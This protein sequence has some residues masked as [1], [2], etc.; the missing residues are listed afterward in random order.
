MFTE[1]RA[2]AEERVEHRTYEVYSE[3]KYRFAVKNKVRFRIKFCY[4]ILHSSNYFSTYSPPLL[5]Y[6]S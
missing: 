6:L 2:K 1:I 4:Q 5:R 3:S